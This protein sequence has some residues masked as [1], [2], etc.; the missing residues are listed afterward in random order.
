MSCQSICR[1]FLGLVATAGICAAIDGPRSVLVSCQDVT[2]RIDGPKLWTPS[3][4]EYKG[5]RMSTESSAYGTVAGFPNVG[6]IGSAHLDKGREEVL[7]LQFFVDGARILTPPDRLDCRSFK[8]VRKSRILGLD[9]ESTVEVRENRLHE[10]AVVHAAV[11]TPLDFMYNF[12]HA[13]ETATSSYLAETPGG[14][15]VRGDLPDGK[16]F[17]RVFYVNREVQWIAI[18]N[19]SLRKGAV[20]RLVEKPAAGGAVAMLWNCP[21]AY[22]KFYLKSFVKQPVPAGFS[23]TYKMVTGF[24]DSAEEH[25][26]A[27]ARKVAAELK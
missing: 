9:L 11:E 2:I 22:R 16:E 4:I 24:F 17:L 15:I 3:R 5:A 1:I 7:D 8:L 21:P 20:S 27:A 13:W 14:E 10:T 23:G 19:R 6:I 18:Y 26:E 25:W 12:M